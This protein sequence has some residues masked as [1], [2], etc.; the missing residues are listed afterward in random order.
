MPHVKSVF[1]NLGNVEMYEFQLLEFLAI[2]HMEATR[3]H[4]RIDYPLGSGCNSLWSLQNGA[5]FWGEAMQF[6][7]YIERSIGRSAGSASWRQSPRSWKRASQSAP[8]PPY[9]VQRPNGTILEVGPILGMAAIDSQRWSLNRKPMWQIGCSWR[10][11][12]EMVHGPSHD[13]MSGEE[14]MKSSRGRPRIGHVW[15]GEVLQ[16]KPGFALEHP[17]LCLT[18]TRA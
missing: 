5:C 18:T 14:S 4:L 2:T 17:V 12:M 8:R 7:H 11:D 13:G 6:M 16:C 3:H 10:R 15:T 1:P 9:T